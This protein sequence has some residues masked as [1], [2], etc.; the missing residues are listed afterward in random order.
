MMYKEFKVTVRLSGG[1]K[2]NFKITAKNVNDAKLHVMDYLNKKGR[3]ITSIQCS[4]LK[5]NQ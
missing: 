2:L 4:V 3:K 5:N 1:E